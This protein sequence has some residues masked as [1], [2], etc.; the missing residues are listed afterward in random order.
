MDAQKFRDLVTVAQDRMEAYCRAEMPAEDAI[1]VC[2]DAL[3]ACLDMME[4]MLD[5]IDDPHEH[6]EFREMLWEL[7]R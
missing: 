3:A 6:L 1:G 2:G 4:R 7:R 5:A